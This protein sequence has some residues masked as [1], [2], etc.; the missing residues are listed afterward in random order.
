MTKRM[1]AW[2]LATILL[3]V[4]AVGVYWNFFAEQSIT[5]SQSELQNRI[6]AKMPFAAKHGVT[7]S[8][9][10][11]VL[12]NDITLDFVASTQKFG[13]EYSLNGAGKGVLTYDNSRG[14]FFFKPEKLELKDFKADGAGISIGDKVGG[15][16]DKWVDSPKIT[17]NKQ[18]IVEAAEVA[19]QRLVQRSAEAVLA[20]TP[21][22]KIPDTLK[23][24]TIRM[25]LH[26]VEVKDGNLV[27]HLSLWQFTVSVLLFGLALLAAIGMVCAL[28]VCPE[29]GVALLV[30][31]SI[32]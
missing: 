27:A 31:G 18:E 9:A 3:L 5:I 16:L 13:K 1:L 24:Q 26:S 12:G 30:L 19:S 22:Y 8:K 4:G 14:A 11:V 2:T 25:F 7:V 10:T 15:L 21:V 23:G 29:W 17:A 28:L 32:S 6:D 20:I